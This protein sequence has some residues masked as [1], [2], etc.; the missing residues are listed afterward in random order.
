MA[1]LENISLWHER[2]I[3]HSSVERIIIPDS[4]LLLDYVLPMFTSIIV[5]L[6]VNVDKMRENVELTHGLVF[7]QRVLIALI[8]KGMTRQEAY[9]VVQTNA[10]DAW[11]NNRDFRTLL[12]SDP[13]VKDRLSTAELDA[14]FD[15]SFYT[16]EVDRI[17]ERAGI[18]GEAG[19]LDARSQRLAPHSY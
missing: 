12:D 8:E 5:G 16:R 6:K 1:S 10:M 17:F 2:D 14:V 11:N 18:T 7:S 3:S 19:P 4:C 13:V 9:K 15:Y